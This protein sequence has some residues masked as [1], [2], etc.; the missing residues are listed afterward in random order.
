[1]SSHWGND[2]SIDYLKDDPD[3]REAWW[4][5]ESIPGS[6]TRLNAAKLWE[7]AL[8]ARGPIVEVGVDQGR[9]AAILLSTALRTQALL[10][11]V[12]SWESCLI[13]NKFKFEAMLTEYPETATLVIHAKSVEAAQIADYKIDMLHIDAN[14][15]EGGVDLDCE[16][17]L[18]RLTSGGIVCFHDYGSTFPAVTAAVDKYTEGWEHLGNWDSLAIR[19]KP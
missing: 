1:M 18:P 19:R 9:S 10:V 14:H 13:D 5:T 17:W 6:F 12:D 7:Y 3:F 11:F 15:Y 8:K 4:Q 2:T 16:A